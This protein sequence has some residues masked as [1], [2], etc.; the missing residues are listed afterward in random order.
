MHS[1]SPSRLVGNNQFYLSNLL[2]IDRSIN[3]CNISLK[4][5]VI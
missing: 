3:F 4:H 2:C 1:Q 5:E